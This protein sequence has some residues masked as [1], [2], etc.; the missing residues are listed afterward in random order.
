[1]FSCVCSVVDHRRSEN[2]ARPLVTHSAIAPCATLLF[3]P[4]FDVICDLLLIRRKT[5]WNLFVK[6][7]KANLS[8]VSPEQ[9]VIYTDKY[10]TTSGR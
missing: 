3:L 5:T 7:M 10:P 8:Q 1:M 4:H 6:L 9:F 2:V